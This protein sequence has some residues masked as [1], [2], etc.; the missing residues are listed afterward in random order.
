MTRTNTPAW[1]IRQEAER[2]RIMPSAASLSD[3]YRI[4]GPGDC[5]HPAESVHTYTTRDWYDTGIAPGTVCDDC[6][7][8]FTRAEIL[9]RW[10]G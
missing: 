1:K 5:E 10:E 2:E 4:D 7:H 6:G 9:D 3:E 8:E